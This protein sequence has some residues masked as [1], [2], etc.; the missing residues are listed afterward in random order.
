MTKTFLK[1]YW[2]IL[3]SVITTAIALAC[4]GDYGEEYGTSNF[5]P[6][7]FVDTAY[8]PFFHSWNFYYGIG[9]D[10]GHI[11]RFNTSNTREWSDYFGQSVSSSTI[12]YF[13]NSATPTSID[14]A[15]T[16]SAAADK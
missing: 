12:D 9:Y 5:T 2:L 11:T 3:T 7:I 1:R 15:I 16:A 14:S 4:A 10:E 8:S 6:S 13:L